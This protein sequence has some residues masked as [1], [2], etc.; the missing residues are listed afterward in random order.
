MGMRAEKQGQAKKPTSKKL[1][2]RPRELEY[3]VK[4]KLR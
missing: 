1:G 2:Q 4:T 3:T